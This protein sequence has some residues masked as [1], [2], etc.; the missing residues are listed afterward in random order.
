MN[1]FELFQSSG[2]YKMA[3]L[4]FSKSRGLAIVGRYTSGENVEV[5][6]ISGEV[7][8]HTGNFTALDY[9]S[10][11]SDQFPVITKGDFENLVSFIETKI[12]DQTC[13][14]IIE[15]EIIRTVMSENCCPGCT[16]YV[17]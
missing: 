11:R 16:D 15:P 3:I 6:Q 7:D 4:Y 5:V 8:P 10:D 1:P 13:M 17:H 9:V 2:I 12:D 14:S